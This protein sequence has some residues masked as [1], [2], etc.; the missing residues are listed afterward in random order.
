DGRAPP[1]RG[2]RRCA[3]RR[4]ER[5]APPP[6]HAVRRA[7]RPRV[8]DRRRRARC[9]R[10][11]GRGRTEGPRA[12][13]GD[14]P[15]ADGARARARRRRARARCRAR[16]GPPARG[17]SG[18][19]AGAR[20]VRRRARRPAHRPGGD[21]GVRDDRRWTGP[22]RPARTAA[23]SAR[24]RLSAVVRIDRLLVD[25]GLVASRERARRLVMAGAVLVGDRP[26]TK[27]GTEVAA[28]AVV[29][30]R[31]TES[32][33]VS[34]GGEKLVG[35]LDVFGVDVRDAVALDVGASTGG[36]TDCLL[37]RGARR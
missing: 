29:R 22:A 27:P 28:D 33:Y 10:W 3:G 24:A 19:V 1:R 21:P 23:S 7:P 2:P 13:Q 31:G 16:R 32:P 9:R 5:A 36:F 20:G 35:A 4:R 12:R 25:R 14:V 6:A 11:T 30:L 15:R 34:R 26:V 17:G 8:P 18:A 37:Q